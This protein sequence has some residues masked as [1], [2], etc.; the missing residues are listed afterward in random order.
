MILKMIYAAFVI[1]YLSALC[2]Q[3][4]ADLSALIKHDTL[5]VDSPV[6]RPLLQGPPAP[7]PSNTKRKEGVSRWLN[8][9]NILTAVVT[10]LLVGALG[11]LIRRV[12]NRME[13]RLS[14]RYTR[15]RYLEHVIEAYQHLPVAGFETNVRVPIPLENV[16][17][18]LRA[19][20]TEFERFR[21]QGGERPVIPGDPQQDRDVTVQ[22]A[23]KLALNKNYDGVV[24]LGHPGSG[25]TTLAKYFLLCFAT[26]KAERSL[27]ISQKLLPILLFL[28][29]IDPAKPLVDNILSALPKDALGVNENF[30]MPCLREGEAI[31]LLDG[32]DEVP[33]EEKRGVV[34]Q[35]I[36][37]EV[38]LAFP[39]CP[40][41]VTSRFSGYRGDAVLSGHYLRLEIRDYQLPQIQQFLK[42][43]LTAVETRVNADTPYWRDQASEKAQDLYGR[44]E[45]TKALRD[46]AMNP[47]MLQIIALVHY[48][49]KTLPERRV[50][51]YKECTD[52]FLER[53]DKAKGLNVLL[54][55]AEARQLLQPVALWMHSVEERREVSRSEILEYI[56]PILPRIKRDVNAEDLLNSWR[57]RSG[58]FKGEGETYFFHHLSFQEYLTA[59]EIRNRQRVD[60]LMEHFDNAWWREPTLLAMG[61]TNPPI[62]ENFMRVLLRADWRDGASVDFMLRCIDETLV[63]TETPFLNALK[64]LERFEARYHALLGL[65]RIGTEEAQKGVET[66]LDDADQRVAG[67]ARSILA[68]W[69]KIPAT[70]KIVKIGVLFNPV[71][72]NAEY[73]LIPGATERT[74]FESTGKPAPDY[75]LYFAKYPVTNFLYR[76]FIDYLSGERVDE[77]M[78]RL[79]R[80]QFAESLLT[81]TKTI[82]GFTEYLEGRDPAAW[83]RKL[84]STLD[85]DKRFNGDDQPVVGVS[86]YAAM[87]YCHWLTELERGSDPRRGGVTPPLHVYRL[88]TEAEWE[89]TASGGE[90]KYPWG[91]EG[92]DDS[93]ANYGEKVGHTT[94]VGAY[95]AGAT[96]DGVMDMAGNVW[97][98]MENLYREDRDWPALRGGSWGD[99]P[100]ALLCAGRSRDLPVGD[101]NNFI[102]FR[103]VC[104]QS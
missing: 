60:L 51:L 31:L 81:K 34:S 58:I 28:R 6:V 95:P 37:R 19:R 2:P 92:P 59:E 5:R 80:E 66:V 43:W 8:W 46:L 62:Y 70:E 78:S 15:G 85:D 21:S 24:I 73:I 52:V 35:W 38:H 96:P 90:R 82:K 17:V 48:D 9:T 64:D 98:W 91:D 47:L 71:E 103:V 75:P 57:E 4:R 74:V 33:T 45:R 61:L 12:Y 3:A 53:W 11:F 42:N 23:L 83:A 25:K 101:W 50:E 39:K 13:K 102:G 1:F 68:K 36:H 27:G 99:K 55:A 76:R 88:P 77:E 87:A 32:L 18:T 84:R 44:I 97:E 40:V 104:R 49:R 89:W 69:G 54:S 10:T 7:D 29:Q 26:G 14:K 65:E 93:R 67:A 56:A 20:L 63:K 16:Y 72:R 22:D 79:P 86:W 41:M 100:S 30:F 94:P